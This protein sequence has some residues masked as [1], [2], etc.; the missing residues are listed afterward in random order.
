MLVGRREHGVD[1]LG[2]EQVRDHDLLEQADDDEKE[3]STRVDVARIV[4][5]LELGHE[6]G[7]SDD[8]AG[9]DVGEERQEHGE[10]DEPPRFEGAAVG[11]DHVAER[12]EGEERDS[13]RQRDRDD[14]WGEVQSELVEGVRRVADE[15]VEVLEVRKH[16][17]V[18]DH[19]AREQP[20]LPTFGVCPVD[21]RG[22]DLVADRRHGDQEAE[23]PVP[24]PVEEVRRRE[25]EEL[26]ASPPGHE[27]PAHREDDHEEDREGDG[28]KEHGYG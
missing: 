4:A 22:E 5:L 27:Q 15:E 24:I 19:G 10:V 1:D 18:R 12:L 25:H 9:D 8:R 2:R 21:G 13:D 6:F 26:P 11:V 7:G 28:G 3:R 14:L 17:E 20:T 23:A 16:A